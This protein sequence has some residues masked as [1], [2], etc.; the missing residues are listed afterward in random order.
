MPWFYR[1]FTR[2]F[3]K[4]TMILPIFYRDFLTALVIRYENMTSSVKPEVYNVLQWCQERT[5]PLLQEHTHN[6]FTTLLDFV[7][8][9]LSEPA[10]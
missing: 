8:D 5:K 9:Y 2:F 10:P 4:C 1:D 7:R 6:H 3:H